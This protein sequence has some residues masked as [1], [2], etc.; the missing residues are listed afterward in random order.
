MRN[1]IRQMGE[2]ESMKEIGKLLDTTPN[3]LGRVL[4]ELGL[5]DE[6]GEPTPLAHQLGMVRNR[7]VYGRETVEVWTWH[8]EKTLSY[9]EDNEIT[10]DKG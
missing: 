10:F 4:K 2:F 9:L 1:D 6:A 3:K 7:P 5:R 8:V